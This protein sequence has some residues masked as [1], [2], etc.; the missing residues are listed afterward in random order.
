MNAG[1]DIAREILKRIEANTFSGRESVALKLAIC[2]IDNDY[3]KS[4]EYAKMLEKIIEADME[5]EEK[6]RVE[7]R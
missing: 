1:Y 7:S 6:E 3:E 4:N 2:L 5:S